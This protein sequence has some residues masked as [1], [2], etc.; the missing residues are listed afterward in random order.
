MINGF[1]AIYSVTIEEMVGQRSTYLMQRILDA[2]RHRNKIF[3]G[4]LTNEDL[5]RDDLLEY[6]SDIME[7]CQLLSTGAEEELGYDGFARNSFQK[8]KI[9]DI[10]TKFDLTLQSCDEYRQWIIDS[11]QG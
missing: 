1:N 9:V 8:S 2:T 3:H 7:W 11:M 4:Q 6:V 5:S 10:H